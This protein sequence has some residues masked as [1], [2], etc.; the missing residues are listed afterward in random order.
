MGWT[1]EDASKVSNLMSDADQKRYR[2]P[3]ARSVDSEVVEQRNFAKACQD[4]GWRAVW[5]STHKPSTANRGT[6]DFIVAARGQTWWIEFKRPKEDLRP[7]QKAFRK[8]LLENG[9]KLYLVYSA[10]EAVD[11][12]ETSGMLA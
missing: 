12:I 4:R 1:K 7:D 2:G 3:Q 11:I 6:P 5:H 8:Q 9:V 10:A